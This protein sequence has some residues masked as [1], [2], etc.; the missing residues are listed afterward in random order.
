MLDMMTDTKIIKISLVVRPLC[1]IEMIKIGR[2]Q[3]K[4][5][6]RGIIQEI[7]IASY[8]SSEK[9]N[10]MPYQY[11]IKSHGEKDFEG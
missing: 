4:A 7:L 6:N 3:D 8:V 5:D 10:I 11:V 1:L 2:L 9:G